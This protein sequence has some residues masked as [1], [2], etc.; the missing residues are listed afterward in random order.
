M[1]IQSVALMDVQKAAQWASKTAE[2][3]ADRSAEHLVS[4]SAALT[5]QMKAV[6]SGFWLAG[7]KDSQWAVD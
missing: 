1:A 5:V 2:L 4:H 7:K 3:T 6:P